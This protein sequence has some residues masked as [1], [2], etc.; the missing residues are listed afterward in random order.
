[1]LK[2]KFNKKGFETN[3]I[4]FILMAIIFVGILIFGF[5]KIFFLK[6]QISEQE[7]IEIKIKLK[8]LF[9]FCDE[10]LNRGSFKKE[11]IKSDLFNGIYLLGDDLLNPNFDMSNFPQELKTIKETG[12][13]IV[14]FKSKFKTENDKI[15][16][17]DFNIIDSFKIEN[18]FS[19]VNFFLDGDPN[20]QIKDT[21]NDG[22]IFLEIMCES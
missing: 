4:F 20:S 7:R 9:E 19:F 11:K 6:E 12:D 16:F 22:I 18:D 3:V 17:I 2:K 8:N 15:I 1:M 10:P 5:N 13:N 14:L 21:K